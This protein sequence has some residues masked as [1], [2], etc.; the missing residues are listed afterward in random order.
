MAIR[1]LLTNILVFC[2]LVALG[3]ATRW[4]SEASYPKLSAATANEPSNLSSIGLANFTAT[5]AA[6]LF[7][8]YFFVPRFAACLVPLAIVVL[9]NLGLPKYNN[10]WEMG[11]AIAMLV[12]PIV[13][14]WFLQRRSNWLRIFGFAAT[15]AILFYLVTDFVLWPGNDLYPHTFSGQIDSYVAAFPFLR[16][17]LLGD[18]FFSGL[19]FGVHRWAASQG[20]AIEQ[21]P[22]L[23][24]APAVRE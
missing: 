24:P 5:T 14:G 8:G 17:M 21:K 23:A 19:I 2:L 18:L 16:N 11:I 6:G 4:I 20:E 9:S 22:Q 3:V 15:P 10:R 1:K 13:L 12:L 7:A